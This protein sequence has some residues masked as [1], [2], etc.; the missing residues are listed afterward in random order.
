MNANNLSGIWT[1]M[2]HPGQIF[3]IAMSSL[4]LFD[5]YLGKFHKAF[6]D[7]IYLFIGSVFIWILCAANMGFVAYALM[8]I[9]IIFTIFIFA[10]I[11][12]DQTLLGIHEK[13]M[14]NSC[15]KQ[16]DCSSEL[17]NN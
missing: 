4:I 10:I 3:S 1:S 11:L 5:I 8:A 12:Y 6:R 9:P 7:I 17:C 14:C 16:S 2:C 15:E 13:G